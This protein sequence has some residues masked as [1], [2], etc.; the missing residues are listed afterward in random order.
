MPLIHIHSDPEEL[1]KV[2]TPHLGIC[3]A[4][5]GF[6]NEMLDGMSPP[7]DHPALPEHDAY[8]QW[9][10]TMP[11]PPGDVNMAE[12][13]RYLRENLPPDAIMTNRAEI[14]VDQIRVPNPAGEI[15]LLMHADRA[16]H[17]VID[18]NHDDICPNLAGGGQFLHG[19]LKTAITG[20][21]QDRTV[22]K[23][24]LCRHCRGNAIAHRP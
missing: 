4:P 1:G 20:K 5:L 11:T 7:E 23:P 21:G 3:S 6:L 17:A 15:N 9:T 18:H 14:R 24:R 8:R 10:D 22:W 19:H 12:I 16:I 13:M 2:Y